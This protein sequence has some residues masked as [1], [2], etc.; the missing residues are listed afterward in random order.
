MALTRSFLKALG[1]EDEKIG[2]I[3]NAHSETVSGLK[4]EIEK[5]K[6]DAE[7]LP[8]VQKKLDDANKALKDADSD[9]YKAKFEAEKAAHD[10]TKAE[11]AEKETASKKDSAF[12]KALKD[13]GYSDK[14]IDKIVKYGGL[15]AEIILN[16]DGTIKDSESLLKRTADEWG[17]Y[18]GEIVTK[19][20]DV[21][22][23]PKSAATKPDDAQAAR[24]AELAA[25]YMADRYGTASQPKKEG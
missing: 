16:D 4:A 6:G 14:G 10:K 7:K 11:Y 25:K 19:G 24:A 20:V 5:Y 2:E 9:G 13:A 18:K 12:R 23:P 15:T 3:I 8:E 22:N 1:I 21:A 17:E